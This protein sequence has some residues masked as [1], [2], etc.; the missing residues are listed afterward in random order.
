MWFLYIFAEAEIA[1]QKG[2]DNGVQNT[3]VHSYSPQGGAAAP[4]ASNSHVSACFTKQKKKE[5]KTEIFISVDFDRSI[6]FP[7]EH[8][9]GVEANRSR[10]QPERQN[11]QGCVAK[12]QQ[13]GNE[14]HN[15]QL[16]GEKKYVNVEYLKT[17]I[18]VFLDT[19]IY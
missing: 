18:N 11:H 12:I 10:Q 19:K 9:S 5:T 3:S 1:G 16:G 13:R 17:E 2:F 8:V 4:H 7:Y 15:V 14:L 6:N